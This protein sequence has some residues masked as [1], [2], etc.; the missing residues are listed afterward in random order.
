MTNR[1]NETT[2]TNDLNKSIRLSTESRALLDKVW[3]KSNE[4]FDSKNKVKIDTIINLGLSQLVDKK[5]K[6]KE[7]VI[8]TL[9][10][11]SL[12]TDD[13]FEIW[14]KIYTDKTG[15]KSNKGFKSLIMSEKWTPFMK[16]NRPEFELRAVWFNFMG[17]KVPWK[18]IIKKISFGNK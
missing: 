11:Q 16:E 10:K 13:Q 18:L 15:D 6:V 2:V 3:K 4:I 12:T 14:R 9:R 17:P 1:S 5:G 7:A 8:T